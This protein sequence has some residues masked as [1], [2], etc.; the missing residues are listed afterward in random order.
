[1]RSRLAVKAYMK[2][3]AAGERWPSICMEDVT[4]ESKRG[5]I[6]CLQSTS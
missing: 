4:N 5:G 3:I 1:M 2:A 6:I